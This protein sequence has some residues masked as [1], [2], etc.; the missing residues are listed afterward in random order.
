MRD[1]KLQNCGALDLTQSATELSRIGKT[2]CM[3]KHEARTGGGRKLHVGD[4]DAL[5]KPAEFCYKL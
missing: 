5:V 1:S 2:Q 4:D 3:A